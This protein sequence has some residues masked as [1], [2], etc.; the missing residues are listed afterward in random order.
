LDSLGNKGLAAYLIATE[1][2]AT[3]RILR[4]KRLLRRDRRGRFAQ[5]SVSLKVGLGEWNPNN[6]E[7]SEK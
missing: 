7:Q 3:V 1:Q 6:S 4:L 5:L 2:T